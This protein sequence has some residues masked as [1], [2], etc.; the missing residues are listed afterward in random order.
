MSKYVI[1]IDPGST[2]G[3][4]VSTY[5]NGELIEL[6]MCN[7]IQLMQYLQGFNPDEVAIHLEDVY[8]SKGAYRVSPKDSKASAAAKGRSIGRC[9]WA[10][11]EVERLCEHFGI[12]LVK[13]RIS[14]CWKDK[15]GKAQFEKVTS[16][17][18]RSNED[19]RSAAYFGWLG[20]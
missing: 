19:T 9:D 10:Q 5:K 15:N 4:G 12:K 2:K 20:L 8:S 7:L 11:V 6:R 16:W 13:H 1:G 17:T 14:K 3:H 18:G